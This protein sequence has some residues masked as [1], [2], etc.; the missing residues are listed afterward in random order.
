MSLTDPLDHRSADYPINQ[1]F[2]KRWSPRAMSGEAISED[3]LMTLFEAAR[4]APSTY[5][6]QEWRYLYATKASEHWQMFFD[7]LVDANQKWCENA[8]ALIVVC[9]NKNMSRNDK[10]NPV[11]SFDAGASFENLC[12]QAADMGIVAHGMAGFDQKAAREVLSVPESFAVEAMIAVGQPG[13]L[14]TL[15]ADLQEMEKPSTRKPLAEIVAE[16]KFSF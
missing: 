14:E 1:L 7:L 6:E 3:Q 5:N 12:L 15:P 16:G 2:L 4:W 13:K 8:A 10:P 9:S 11:H